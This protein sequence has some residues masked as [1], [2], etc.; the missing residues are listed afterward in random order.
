MENKVSR[1]LKV[2]AIVVFIIGFISGLVIWANAT[3]FIVLIVMWASSFVAGMLFLGLAE[4][5][6]LLQEISP[7]QKE[8]VKEVAPDFSGHYRR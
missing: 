1:V 8:I 2:I 5:I 7:I 4:I 3:N 6:K